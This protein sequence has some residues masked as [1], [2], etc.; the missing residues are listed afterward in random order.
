[1]FP[2]KLLIAYVVSFSLWP[3]LVFFAE[4]SDNQ[5]LIIEA[6]NADLEFCLI[7][8]I[9]LLWVIIAAVWHFR[10]MPVFAVIMILIAMWHIG[11]TLALYFSASF[12]PEST[13]DLQILNCLI[14]A[15]IWA[16]PFVVIYLVWRFWPRKQA[17]GLPAP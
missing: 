1:M 5:R 16:V 12:N 6:W 9:P 13:F 17:V 8:C 10:R 15:L 14:A 4:E 7:L 2:L 11:D 3:T